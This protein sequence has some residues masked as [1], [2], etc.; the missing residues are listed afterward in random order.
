MMH[1]LGRIGFACILWLGISTGALLASPSDSL[2][3]AWSALGDFD[4]RA[5]A[6]V[7]YAKTQR[8]NHPEVARD[9]FE[10][11]REQAEE[12]E[13]PIWIAE[14]YIQLGIMEYLVE[15]MPESNRYYFEALAVLQ[16]AELPDLRSRIYNNIGWNHERMNSYALARDYFSRSVELA[17]AAGDSVMLGLVLNNLAVL[18][19]NKQHY[20]SALIYL[21]ESLSLNRALKSEA[22]VAYNLNNIGLNY[23]SLGQYEQAEHYFQEALVINGR[24]GDTIEMVNNVLNLTRQQFRQGKYQTARDSLLVWLPVVKTKGREDQYQ[25]WLEALVFV[26]KS[27]GQFELALEKQQELDGLKD[28]L[29]AA[30][31]VESMQ[32]LETQYEVAERK[33]EL[34]ATQEAIARQNSWLIGI[35]AGLVLA[36]MGVVFLVYVYRNQRRAETAMRALNAEISR[37]AEALQEANHEIRQMNANLEDRVQERTRVIEQQSENLKRFAFLTSHRIRAALAR[38]MGLTDLLDQDVPVAEQSN[39]M[40][41][42]KSSAEE[43]DSL[44]HELNQALHDDNLGDRPDEAE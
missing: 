18:H 16:E 8:R 9:V 22:Q 6:M 10:Y 7:D 21:E 23:H 44:V 11:L 27:I 13:Q 42:L 26:T 33:R 25:S 2:Q 17:R 15:D 12:Q 19:K 14:A 28:S 3:E 37:Q 38:V 31:L 35:G 43:M 1:S 36:L 41:K 30:R 32:E 29:Q 34:L 4:A 39:L 40:T 20:D 24:R 5:Q